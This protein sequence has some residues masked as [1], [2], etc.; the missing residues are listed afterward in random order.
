[1]MKRVKQLLVVFV[2]IVA[3]LISVRYYR[4]QRDRRLALPV[5]AD[6]GGKVGSIPFE[7]F[8][9]E[10]RI[11]FEGRLLTREDL[12]RLVALNPLASRNSVGI[13]FENSGLTPEDIQYVKQILPDVHILPMVDD[14][15]EAPE[16]TPG[17]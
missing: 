5:V 10:Y 16:A 13:K 1:M 17:T 8:G 15:D 12:D 3:T 4:H 7:P 11:S 9:S 2:A 14:H 6:L